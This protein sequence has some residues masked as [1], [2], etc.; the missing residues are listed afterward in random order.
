MRESVK[1]RNHHGNDG[2]RQQQRH[3][4]RQAAA[5]AAAADDAGT[6]ESGFDLPAPLSSPLHGFWQRRSLQLKTL[7]RICTLVH[8]RVSPDHAMYVGSA[9]VAP[10][11]AFHHVISATD[12]GRILFYSVQRWDFELKSLQI[13]IEDSKRKLFRKHQLEMN[14]VPP[15]YV[16]QLS[17]SIV[18]ITAGQLNVMQ[19]DTPINSIVAMTCEGELYIIQVDERD[20]LEPKMVFRFDTGTLNSYCLCIQ[21]ASIFVSY[22]RGSLE[23]WQITVPVVKH[24]SKRVPSWDQTTTHLLWR[25]SFNRRILSL[26]NIDSSAIYP[27]LAVCTEQPPPREGLGHPT[28]SSTLDVL[29]IST[30]PDCWGKIDKSS[31]ESPALALQD[32]LV[33]PGEGMEMIDSSTDNSLP[34][35]QRGE[36]S[37][38]SDRLLSGEGFF[39]AVLSDGT[40]A[41]LRTIASRKDGKLSL[42]WG[43]RDDIHQCL[44]QYPA[45]GMGELCL[46]SG[47]HIA[48]CLRGGTTYLL[49]LVSQSDSPSDVPVFLFPRKDIEDD[50]DEPLIYLHGFTAGNL[51]M[52]DEDISLPV[53]VYAGEGGLM[54]VY[55]CDLLARDCTLAAQLHLCIEEMQQNGSIELLLDVLR[56]IKEGDPLLEI[57]EWKRAHSETTQASNK[58]IDANSVVMDTDK[59][60]AIRSLA[61]QLATI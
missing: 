38:G 24:E 41:V 44:L 58:G 36:A 14:A 20:L 47:R 7:R 13:G 19:M 50:D 27:Y 60:P 25:G 29:D 18:A 40:A 26:S 4:R 54:E 34:R 37:M 10:I 6:A 45:I 21:D 39:A 3:P 57:E 9:P 16:V 30:M 35:R 17:G 1:H 48:C 56:S 33:W 42:S 59:F 61:L 53:L 2:H 8:P 46:A 43:I 51:K 52:T 5:A 55:S 32:F 22:R 12:D 23:A 28:S 11:I 31:A 49:P 15:K